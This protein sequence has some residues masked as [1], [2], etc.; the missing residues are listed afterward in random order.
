M[1][2]LTSHKCQPALGIAWGLGWDE[3]LILIEIIIKI[4]HFHCTKFQLK[5][6]YLQKLFII[7]HF[8]WLTC[9][10]DIIFC[11]AAGQG[12]GESMSK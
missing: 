5:G 7:E 12:K 3:E 6:L 4:C 2:W 10:Q 9:K 1:V 8:T 11:F